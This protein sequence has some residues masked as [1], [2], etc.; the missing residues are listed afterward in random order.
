MFDKILIANRG[1]IACRVIKTARKMGIGT[2]AIYSDADRNALHVEMAD[3]AVHIGPPPANQSYIVIDKVMDAIT[4]TG[5]QAVHPGYGFL[6]ENAKFAEALEAAGVAFI[7]PPKGAIEAMGDK[8][9][10]KKIAQD[11]GVSTVPGYMGL[12]EDADEAVKISNEIGYPVM[13]KASAGGGG[14]GMRIAWS[15]EEAREGFQSSKNEAANS[16]GDDRIFIEKFVTQ[17]RHIEIQ[18][19]CDAHGNGIYLNERECSIQRRN[20]KVIEEAPSPFL[21]AATRK[22]MGEQSVA[23]AKAVGYTSA[24]TVEFIVDGDRNFYFLEMNTRLQVEHPVTELITGVDLVEQMIRVANGEAL[25]ITQD[26][27]QINGWA[28]ESR[29]YAEDPYRNF[30]PSIGRLTRYRPPAEVADDTHAV[31]ND[32][33]VY[34]GGEIS[35]YYDPM[36]AKLCTW[37]PTRGEAIE[38]MRKALD[39]FE[40]EGIGHNLPFCSAVM[41]HPKFV[42]GDMTTAFIA[43]EYPDGFEGVQLDNAALE[44]IAAATA[45]MYRVAE[46]RRSRI[47]GRLD[48]HERKVGRNWVVSLQGESFALEIDADADGATVFLNDDTLRVT[49]D[50]V[51]GQSLARLTVGDTPLVLK[52]DQITNGFRI[53]NRGADLDVKIYSPRQAELAALM[54]EKL[55]PDTSKMLLCPMPGL[56]VKVDVAVGDE[57]Q[58]GQALC[59]V[60]AMKMENILRAEK[61]ATISKINAGAGDSLAVDDVIMEFE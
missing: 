47:S 51:S 6:S 45:A 42:S 41:D 26:D 35:M 5:A 23:L 52:V 13:I 16:F 9:T 27:V 58:E 22:A 1:E 29:L 8:I 53:R 24:G 28:M 59:T 25:T 4:Q 17:P 44:R 2:V 21:D 50:W 12:I 48:N 55:P 30:L 56:I 33:G 40:V 15:D 7:G 32:T 31:R 60:E 46:I 38:E 54:P 36:I 3:E 10:S 11:A 49:S 20:Q 43:E 34:E 19:L 57:V 39:A 61:R 37:A 18:V 14:K